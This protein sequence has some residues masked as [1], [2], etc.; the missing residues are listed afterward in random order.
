MYS[1]A[2]SQEDVKLT[3]V[4]GKFVVM[5][6]QKPHNIIKTN[7][8]T[9]MSKLVR[10]DGNFVVVRVKQPKTKQKQT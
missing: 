10:V 2:I 8:C 5:R 9:V 7:K 6:T 4:D 3:W 1:T